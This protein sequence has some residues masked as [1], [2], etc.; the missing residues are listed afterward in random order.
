[1]EYTW[2]NVA[3]TIYIT[4]MRARR[5]L[6]RALSTLTL[7]RLKQKTHRRLRGPSRKKRFERGFGNCSVAAKCAKKKKNLYGFILRQQ[8]EE[9]NGGSSS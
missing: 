4:I 5:R 7:Q 3:R 1:M 8:R 2:K 9:G 6:Y